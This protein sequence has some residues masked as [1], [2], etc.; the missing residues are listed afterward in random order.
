MQLTRSRSA[1]IYVQR[2]WRGAAVR[3]SRAQSDTSVVL[4]QALVCRRQARAD[5]KTSRILDIRSRFG[6]ASPLPF[7]V[8]VRVIQQLDRRRAIVELSPKIYAVQ[9]HA[10]RV[11]QGFPRETTYRRNME[12]RS[13]LQKRDSIRIVARA[14]KEANDTLD[15]GAFVWQEEGPRI[16]RIARNV[17]KAR[18]RSS[19][20]ATSASPSLFK[21]VANLRLGRNRF[22]RMEGLS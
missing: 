18:S 8:G 6:R 7:T 17:Q 15:G 11:L 1:C 21:V 14:K 9:H 12:R 4:L 5:A 19:A 16:H 20:V 22:W 10:A 2:C 3:S 13:K